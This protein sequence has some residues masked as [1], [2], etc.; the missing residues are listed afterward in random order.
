M[1][2][3]L[4][5]YLLISDTSPEGVNIERD[6]KAERENAI[7]DDVISLKHIDNPLILMALGYNLCLMSWKDVTFLIDSVGDDIH[8]NAK[9]TPILVDVEKNMLKLPILVQK[10]EHVTHMRHSHNGWVNFWASYF[11]LWVDWKAFFF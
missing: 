7:D 6:E 2:I 4:S 8:K 9:D 1:D 5:Q 3:D 11:L 10:K